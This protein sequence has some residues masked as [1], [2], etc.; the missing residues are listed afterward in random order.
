M[1]FEYKS[2]FN[3]VNIL[4][5]R[6]ARCAS[7]LVARRHF[8]FA[9]GV[10]RS[11]DISA[12]QP[13][14]AGSSLLA[15]LTNSLCLDLLQQLGLRLTKSCILVPEATG[16]AIVLCLLT[17]RSIRPNSEYVIWSRIDQKSCFKSILTAG[18]KPLVIELQHKG[19]ELITNAAEIQNTISTIGADKIA[20]VIT[21]TS[22]F[23]PR[24]PDD[25][26]TVAKICHTHSIPHI[27]N[28]AYGLQSTK[29]IHLIQEALRIGRVDAFVQ[30][31]DKNLMVPVGGAIIGSGNKAFIESVSQTYPGR[32]SATP[33]IDTF[34]TLLNLGFQGYQNLLSQRTIVFKYLNEQLKILSSKHN[35]RVLDTPHNQISLGMSLSNFQKLDQKELTNIGSM[36]FTRCVSGTRVIPVYSN[37]TIIGP[38]MFTNFGAHSNN[39]TCSYLTAAAAIGIKIEDVDTYI[40]RL[41]TVL[42]KLTKSGIQNTIPQNVESPC[43]N[44]SNC[45]TAQSRGDT[46]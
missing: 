18:Y 40:K 13:K 45:E 20:C 26:P 6:E 11:G 8:H 27:I 41:D 36:L 4:G 21:T 44:P 39:Y 25:I 33:C 30:S 29:C 42:I 24:V 28:N 35:E 1:R 14:A 2:E 12:I 46:T 37:E 22:C 19:D 17:I 5:E 43:T 23:A 9:H 7:S 31:T 34:I 10:G 32:A 38:H 3:Q 16:M 15:Q